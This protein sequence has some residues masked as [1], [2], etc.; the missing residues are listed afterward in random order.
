MAAVAGVELSDAVEIP[1]HVAEAAKTCSSAWNTAPVYPTC[2]TFHHADGVTGADPAMLRRAFARPMA[3]SRCAPP[4]RRRRCAR[5]PM[6]CA[7]TVSSSESRSSGTKYVRRMDWRRNAPCNVAA[8]SAASGVRPG[9]HGAVF[10]PTKLCRDR[11][12]TVGVTLTEGARWLRSSEGI[13]SHH[14]FLDDDTKELPHRNYSPRLST[15][16]P[17]RAI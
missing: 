7:Q 3:G 1:A 2:L 8:I 13:E 17:A 16:R 6:R 11:L 5:A 10:Q 14:R 4:P 15:A 9:N 12:N